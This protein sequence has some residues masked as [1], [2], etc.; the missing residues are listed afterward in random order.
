MSDFCF[1]RTH[2]YITK[3]KNIIVGSFAMDKFRISQTSSLSSITT[4]THEKTMTNH[5]SYCTI[6]K[7]HNHGYCASKNSHH[8]SAILPEIIKYSMS[9]FHMMTHNHMI[10]VIAHQKITIIMS[11]QFY[12]IGDNPSVG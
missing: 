4:Q 7:F 8:D 1:S 9:I 5:Y 6:R 11:Q 12:R 3:K 2:V 10:I